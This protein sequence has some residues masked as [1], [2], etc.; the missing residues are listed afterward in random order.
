MGYS[1]DLFCLDWQRLGNALGSGD[2]AMIDRVS[3]GT[4]AAFFPDAARRGHDCAKALEGLILGDYGKRLRA[5][6]VDAAMAEPETVTAE[7]AIAFCALIETLGQTAGQVI[8]NSAAGTA[9][10]DRFLFQAQVVLQSPVDLDRLIQRPLFGIVHEGY[11]AWGGLSR[12]EVAQVLSRHPLE[13][14]PEME[15][16]DQDEWLYGILEAL[17]HS[18]QAG[19]DSITLYR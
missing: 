3:R 15:D 7:V 13:E 14:L 12:A 4:G 10:R 2:L 19:V 8:H 16:S 1:L 9:F 11:P 17:Q 18:R 5:R 6:G